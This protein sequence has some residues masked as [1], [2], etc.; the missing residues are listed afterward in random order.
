[1]G[2]TFAAGK[3]KSREK[4]QT[5]LSSPKPKHECVLSIKATVNSNTSPLKGISA[6]V[7][8]IFTELS[9]HGEITGLKLLRNTKTGLQKP[10]TSALM[11]LLKWGAASKYLTCIN[12]RADITRPIIGN[13]PQIFKLVITLGSDTNITKT[14]EENAANMV[15][16]GIIIEVKCL[17]VIHSKKKIVIAMLPKSANLKYVQEKAQECL[18]KAVQ[19]T[20]LESGESGVKKSITL[21]LDFNILMD[22]GYPS[23]NFEKFKQGNKTQYNAQNKQMSG[24][25]YNAEAEGWIIKAKQNFKNFFRE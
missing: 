17:K 14:V 12:D 24:M 13:K 5:T 10:I 20:I 8:T 22:V 25:E 3:D 1:M 15:Q 7:K 11:V 18:I 4:K 9:V 23:K 19:K 2:Q 21:A 16:G 6:A